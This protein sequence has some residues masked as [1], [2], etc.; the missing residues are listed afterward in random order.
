MP[1]VSALCHLVS[2]RVV[3]CRW[4]RLCTLTANRFGE[5]PASEAYNAEE[6][7]RYYTSCPSIG[8]IVAPGFR[9]REQLGGGGS[10]CGA[11]TRD[12][13]GGQEVSLSL[14]AA[15]PPRVVWK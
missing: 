7:D 15:N 9:R 8:G 4:E 6:D 13:R 1:H 2:C 14:R 11:T 3:S 12:R 5:G 10:H